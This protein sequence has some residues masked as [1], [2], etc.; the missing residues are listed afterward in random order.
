MN[1]GPPAISPVAAQ[2]VRRRTATYQDNIMAA[3]GQKLRRV[4][5]RL[6]LRYRD[7]VEAS[8]SIAER[9][10]NPEF[11]IALSRLA[12]IENRGRLPS[13]YRLYSL[14]AIYG[15]KPEEVLGWYGIDINELPRDSKICSKWPTPAQQVLN[16]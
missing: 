16:L 15:L 12:D 10:N 14:C 7:V 13:I 2:P 1:D 6:N 8:R 3:A 4:R 9:H 5:E 11:A